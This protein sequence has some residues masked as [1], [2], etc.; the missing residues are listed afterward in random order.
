[1]IGSRAHYH[2]RRTRSGMAGFS[3]E[4]GEATTHHR[5]FSLCSSLSVAASATCHAISLIWPGRSDGDWRPSSLSLRGHLDA[6]PHAGLADLPILGTRVSAFW[7]AIP[8]ALAMIPRD[9]YVVV[10]GPAGLQ[11]R[12]RSSAESSRSDGVIRKTLLAMRSMPPP[13][14]QTTPLQKSIMRRFSS[15]SAV[16]RFT[17]TG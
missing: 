13:S 7:S 5:R 8:H 1:M 14:P 16:W 9:G 4:E 3:A 2:P 6:D 15:R 12:R 11:A 17:I 10:G